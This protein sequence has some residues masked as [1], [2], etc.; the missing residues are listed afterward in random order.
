MSKLF[1]S[2]VYSVL[3]IPSLFAEEKALSP[4]GFPPS[5]GVGKAIVE[6]GK[7]MIQLSIVSITPM[8]EEI[9][10]QREGKK[11]REVKTCYATVISTGSFFIDGKGANPLV[12]DGKTRDRV[13]IS[14]LQ[15]VRVYYKTGKAVLQRDLP[16]LFEK[17]RPILIFGGDNIDPYYLQVAHEQVLVITGAKNFVFPPDDQKR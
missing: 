9:L 4:M 7:A 10:V 12:R 13:V 16:K 1:Y 6:D 14:P 17:E 8:T 2:L 5:F 11:V 3:L 15:G